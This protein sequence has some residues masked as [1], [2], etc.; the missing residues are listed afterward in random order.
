[1]LFQVKWNIPVM[2]ELCL[3]DKNKCPVSKPR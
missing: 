2:F 1:M 3:R